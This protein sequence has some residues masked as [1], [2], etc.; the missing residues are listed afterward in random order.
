LGPYLLTR[1]SVVPDTSALVEYL[2]RTESFEW[3]QTGISE[4]ITTLQLTDIFSLYD[5]IY[6]ALAERLS[7]TLLTADRPFAKSVSAHLE[8]ALIVEEE[9]L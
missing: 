7:G 5:A 9:A 8:I 4:T 3:I 6:V 1:A 2:L